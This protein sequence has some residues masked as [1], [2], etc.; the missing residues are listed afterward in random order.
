MSF[1]RFKMPE[2]GTP[3]ATLATPA[4]FQG[5]E[6]EKPKRVAGIARVAGAP[7]QNTFFATHA[8]PVERISSWLAE[9]DRLPKACGPHGQ[10]LRAITADFALGSWA[11][12]AVRLGWSDADLFAL[13]GGLIPE[14]SR[15]ALH[16]RTIG[17]DAISLIDGKGHPEAWPRPDLG[18]AV[19]WWTHPT[20]SQR[21]VHCDASSKTQAPRFSGIG[22]HHEIRSHR[23]A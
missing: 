18:N 17:T 20:L 15:R 10:R 23:K 6:A 4:T 7:R 5:A 1:P 21:R 11:H 12:E 9:M 8:D 14:M 13:D 22:E 16:F 19:P 3:P 2:T